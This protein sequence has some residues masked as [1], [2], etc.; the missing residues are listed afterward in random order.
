MPT[1]TGKHRMPEIG[2]AT[3]RLSPSAMLAPRR[4]MTGRLAMDTPTA[5]ALQQS[6]RQS[7]APRSPAMSGG[8]SE[9]ESDPDVKFQRGNLLFAQGEIAAAATLFFEVLAVRPDFAAA[10]NNLGN[11]LSK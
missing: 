10:H 4:S 11:A 8:R 3:P 6:S 9:S 2:R 1:R 5:E 7:T